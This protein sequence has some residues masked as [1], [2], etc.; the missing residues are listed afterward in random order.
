MSSPFKAKSTILVFAMAMGLLMA[1]LDNTIVS[2]C[3]SSVIKDL[4]GFDSMS[5]VFT[6][7]MLASTSTMLIF[8]KLSDI[9]GRKL[10]YL[11]GIAFF[12]IG[13]AL[14]GQAQSMAE[15]IGFRAVQGI[16]SGALFP[17]SFS[18]IYAAFPDQKQAAKLTGVFAGIF[19]ISSVLGPQLGTFITSHFS[20]RW[21][22]YVNV[23]FGIVSFLLLLFAVKE[24]KA[25]KKPS[26]D[27]LGTLL[28]VFSTVSLMLGLTWGGKD[29]AWNSWQI[30]G[31]FALSLVG[32]CM[33]LMVEMKVKEPILPLAIY[34]NSVV[35]G[36]SILSFIQGVVMFS[37][38][39]Y[40]PIF[41]VAVLGHKNSNSM[42]TPLMLSLLVGASL[43]G[44]LM[45]KLSYRTLLGGSSLIGAVAIYFLMT[46]S[47]SAS[48]L[49]M[50]TVMIVMGVCSIGPL[51]SMSQMGI[52]QNVSEEYVGLSSSLGGFWRNIGAV[53]GTSITATV[54][55]NQFKAIL[56]KNAAEAHIPADKVDSLANPQLIMNAKDSLP[57]PWIHTLQDSL[58]TAI[59]H[60]YIVAFTFAVLAIFVSL[61]IKGKASPRTLETKAATSSASLV[62]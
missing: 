41:S 43:A 11:I 62:D 15:L 37:A 26:I 29:Y 16:G 19:G 1:A 38:I 23:P 3:I 46:A 34:K 22:F 9:L 36:I 52:A 61:A 5:W 50:I 56:Q 28:L 57:A 60:G 54:V 47:H 48:S 21:C 4:S 49:Y 8:G 58:G 24:S 10:F 30:L 7:Y 39:S 44:G 35:S 20:W 51:M 2:A 45:F 32:I 31:L 17:I 33:F 18:I 55:N 13:S 14:C 42:L 6:S 40:I 53:V 27:Y 25:S 59:N 12:L